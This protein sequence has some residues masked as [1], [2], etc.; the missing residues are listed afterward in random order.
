M[1]EQRRRFSGHADHPHAMI[2]GLSNICYTVLDEIMEC[3]F[4]RKVIEIWQH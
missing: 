1:K 2:V 4:L 3:I